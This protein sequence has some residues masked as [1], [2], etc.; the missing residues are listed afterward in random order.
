MEDEIHIKEINPISVENGVLINGFPSSGI[1][2]AIATESMINTSN[3][4]LGGITIGL[5]ER[6]M[7]HIA[8]IT[9]ASIPGCKIGPPVAIAYAVE[10]VGVAKI[11]PSPLY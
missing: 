1:T 11:N 2:S 3:F 10:P 5:L 6:L 4:E 9:I 7:G 8:V